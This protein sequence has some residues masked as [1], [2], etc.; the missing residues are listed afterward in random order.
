MDSKVQ[1][2]QQEQK[3]K[4]EEAKKEEGEGG[5]D[6][7]DAANTGG[8]DA[9]NDLVSLLSE[10]NK[11]KAL[12]AGV[13]ADKKAMAIES[14]FETG[15]LMGE[16]GADVEGEWWANENEAETP[17]GASAGQGFDFN[18]SKPQSSGLSQHQ[19]PKVKSGTKRLWRTAKFGSSSGSANVPT[20]E[21]KESLR[22]LERNPPTLS[23]LGSGV[24]IDTAYSQ[25]EREVAQLREKIVLQQQQQKQQKPPGS[26]R[27]G[28]GAAV[29]MDPR[30]NS[31]G[32]Q[33][34]PTI[35][36]AAGVH[37]NDGGAG[38]PGG[39][40]GAGVDADALNAAVLQ[41]QKGPLMVMPCEVIKPFVCTPGNFEIHSTHI[42]FV[43][44]EE[45]E[46]A[47]ED[48]IA[49]A[50]AEI[51]AKGPV[52]AGDGEK[53]CMLVRGAKSQM[54]PLEQIGQLLGRR[55]QLRY[56]AVELF[57]TSGDSLLINLHTEKDAIAVFEKLRALVSHARNA[58]GSG[59]GGGMMPGG[60]LGA[61]AGGAAGARAAKTR[62][63]MDAAAGR[64]GSMPMSF[65]PSSTMRQYRQLTDRWV[66]RQ[67][68]NFEYL[69]EL[70][71]IAGRTY[72]DLAQ[73]PI[74]PWVLSNYESAELDLTDE[75]NYRD[76]S[77]PMGIQKEGQEEFFKQ[78]YEMLSEQCTP[79]TPT[80]EPEDALPPFHYG[81]HFSTPGFALW[82]LMRLEPYTSLHIHL[83]DGRFDR[84]DRLFDS[85]AD[86]WTGCTN[87]TSDVKELTPEW[88]YLP[89]MFVNNNRL[90]LGLKQSG[91]R[92]DDVKLPPWAEGSADVF[93]RKH[94]EALES[95][96]V[97]AHLH[98]WIDLVFGF[99]QRGPEAEKSINVYY[100]LTYENSVDLEF[101]QVT[102]KK[103]Y[104]TIIKQID[105]Y[106]QTPPQLFFAPHDPRKTP[107]DFIF[108]LFSDRLGA[109][110]EL[111]R[112][113][114]Q[115]PK[116]L[117]A[118]PRY[119]TPA[120]QP[121]LF[122]AECSGGSGGGSERLVTVD[123][124][125][126]LGLHR[127]QVLSPDIQPPFKLQID[128]TTDR[129]VGVPFATTGV[130]ST[131]AVSTPRTS[132]PSRARRDGRGG[133]SGS[134]GRGA[135]RRGSERRERERAMQ[136]GGQGV[137][138]PSRATSH[139]GSPRVSTSA[140]AGAGAAHMS[141]EGVEGVE[142]WPALFAV[143]PD[144]RMLYSCGHWDNSF[145]VTSIDERSG[146]PGKCVQSLSQHQDV[147]TCLAVSE[148]GSVLV[149]GSS[150]TSVMVW[151]LLRDRPTMIAAGHI[152]VGNSGDGKTGGAADGTGVGTSAQYGTVLPSPRYTFHGHDDAVRCVAC[153]TDHDLV[154]SA[155][156]D[157]TAIVHS[158][159]SGHYVRSILPKSVSASGRPGSGSPSAI[160][161][162]ASPMRGGTQGGSR[163]Q[164]QQQHAR[165]LAVLP[166]IQWVG[167]SAKGD[168]VT[169]SSDLH[170]TV[171]NINGRQIV[172]R[173]VGERLH[174]LIFSED[175][176]YIVTGG[177]SRMV[178]VLAVHNLVEV[179]KG[180]DG[181][182]KPYE[183]SECSSKSSSSSS[184]SRSGSRSGS[185]SK[186]SSSS[187]SSSR[188]GSRSG[189]SS[190]S[191]S[192]SSESGRAARIGVACRRSRVSI[193]I[194]CVVSL[195]SR[196]ALNPRS[197]TFGSL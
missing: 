106:G 49:V 178:R 87:N 143:S 156:D 67:L 34:R 41:R 42:S 105:N 92:V 144:G 173:N 125:R 147:V 102:N 168:I 123:C 99:K 186:S 187:S 15:D 183:V 32:L 134:S 194:R 11:A 108:P 48:E 66:Q 47:E 111:L 169:Y 159:R 81:S 79:I 104:G 57:L 171:Y 75:K 152:H 70:N 188:S 161:V 68:S 120:K 40:A 54:V 162:N 59:G 113:A 95:E 78:R 71:R 132:S 38:G 148:D 141:A 182:C 114:L 149:T 127:W 177:A 115:K 164:R 83:Q 179:Q 139:S 27:R 93:V 97:S 2:E 1:K 118:F 39:G 145:K 119:D 43:R 124:R 137:G 126:T 8:D 129:R 12:G 184:S 185:S 96:H 50:Q 116:T 9:Q 85:V 77:K 51:E 84:P 6:G 165:S 100:H 61:Q 82:Y 29:A 22:R 158:L 193:S 80:E 196:Q 44:N 109:G 107:E 20:A 197:H 5:S 138:S 157:G 4:Q 94:R 28:A 24:R 91:V 121:V 170:I 101:L 136:R 33:E 190:K 103:L 189:S 65:Y 10:L 112:P 153:S 163:Q 25:W 181:S 52:K 89:E 60:P 37:T 18:R 150:D 76:L 175:G 140:D 3:R 55:Y 53:L 117:F 155:G 35:G 86:T 151:Q 7:K 122:L 146:K 36:A 192:S 69:M 45:N 56:C 195:G 180:I 26:P 58:G 160:D 31:N 90:D 176:H 98:E 88:F 17:M 16:L 166:R 131:V 154:V 63:W 130:V 14:G 128:P 191:S 135:D 62:S 64:Y 23:A 167:I 46:I 21:L 73:Y 142:V 74:F 30:Y 174:A 172:R 19:P 133:G 72:N 13:A 110:E